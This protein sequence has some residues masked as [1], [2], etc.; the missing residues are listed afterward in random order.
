M[1]TGVSKKIQK[2]LGFCLVPQAGVAIGLV[3][4]VQAS[5]MLQAAPPIVQ[6]KLIMLVNIILFS[7]FLNELFGPGISKFGII[8]GAD[9]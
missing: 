2:F 9:L 7:V 5:P 4:L 6:E 8:R 3:L 1:F